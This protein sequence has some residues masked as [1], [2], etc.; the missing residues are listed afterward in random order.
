MIFNFELYSVI[1]IS[2]IALVVR[3]FGVLVIALLLMLE[4]VCSLMLVHSF[5]YIPIAI[6]MLVP[7]SVHTVSCYF[8]LEDVFAS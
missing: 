8:S 5:T 1:F 2:V 4:L 3:Y 6:S 7:A